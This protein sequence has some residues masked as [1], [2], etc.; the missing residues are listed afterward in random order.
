MSPGRANKKSYI[1]QT[2]PS[3][4]YFWG[5]ENFVRDEKNY[6]RGA[7][8]VLRSFYNHYATGL[9]GLIKPSLTVSILSNSSM[10]TP[11]FHPRPEKS[12]LFLINNFDS[13]GSECLQPSDFEFLCSSK[14]LKRSEALDLNYGAARFDFRTQ[15]QNEQ[16]GET[17]YETHGQTNRHPSTKQRRTS[18]MSV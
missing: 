15:N 8:V 4:Q 16:N 10:P 5:S 2:N 3:N 7:G 11:N 14:S 6:I 12:E 1:K 17:I 18:G 9:T 13:Q